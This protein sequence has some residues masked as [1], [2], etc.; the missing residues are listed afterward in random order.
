M[1]HSRFCAL[2]M[3]LLGAGPIAA[4]AQTRV[5]PPT[6]VESA[7]LA[8]PSSSAT[9]AQNAQPD[10][11][12]S[13]QAPSSPPAQ[14]EPQPVQPP[15]APQGQ[16]VPQPVQPAPTP[17]TPVEPQPVQPPP[18]LPPPSTTPPTQQ[19]T[20]VP[21]P[22]ATLAGKP[23]DPSDVDEIA[24]VA[25]PVLALSGQ[26]SWDQGF[27]RLSE[28]FALLRGEA[29]KANL[30]VAGR[31]LTLFVETDD[32]GFKFTAMLPVVASGAAPAL[33]N[34]VSLGQSPSGRSL[35]FVHTAPYDDIDS[36]YET[37]TAY[38]EAKN[39][40]VKDAFLEEYVSELKD[41]ADPN[42]EI[43]VYVQPK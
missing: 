22:N 39:I 6:A 32:N 23:G 3:A 2:L 42:L 15:P 38:L 31:P 17:Q 21:N 26:A 12:P 37:I 7:P 8:P 36:T 1:R 35:R 13:T 33:G 40:L 16:V 25:R 29:G 24:L 41:P 10:Q 34:G 5:A 30:P 19:Q 9:P 18:T 4:A 43:N 27:Q 14:S 20:G 28:S 11:A